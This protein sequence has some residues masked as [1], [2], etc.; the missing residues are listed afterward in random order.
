MTPFMSSTQLDIVQAENVELI[1][2]YQLPDDV[3]GLLLICG[4]RKAINLCEYDDYWDLLNDAAY[5]AYRKDPDVCMDDFT[6][7]ILERR[8]VYGGLKRYSFLTSAARQEDKAIGYSTAVFSRRFA[9]HFLSKIYDSIE[10]DFTLLDVSGYRDR[11]NISCRVNGID[12]YLP[13]SFS[14]EGCRVRYSFGNLFAPTDMAHITLKYDAHS[15]EVITESITSRTLRSEYLFDFES[16]ELM[17]RVLENN[18]IVYFD[19]NNADLY[20]ADMTDEIRAVCGIEDDCFVGAEMPWGERIFI[21]NDKCCGELV[22]DNGSGRLIQIYKEDCEDKITGEIT[23]VHDVFSHDGGM[24]VQ[25]ELVSSGLVKSVDNVQEGYYY[26][27][28]GENGIE[29][30][31][32]DLFGLTSAQMLDRYLYNR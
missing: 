1:R 3:R 15:L 14:A 12:R 5:K 2:Y 24:L 20:A 31:N 23:A 9:G 4:D 21:R 27:Y 13:C 19:K 17:Q 26:R 32:D 10:T 16:G 7:Q 25:T 11:F 18:E 22:S 8:S 6:R 29:Y 30:I 28:I